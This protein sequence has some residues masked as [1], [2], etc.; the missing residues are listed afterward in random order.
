MEYC[1]NVEWER[2][3]GRYKLVNTSWL[4]GSEGTLAFGS[5][6]FLQFSLYRDRM[7]QQRT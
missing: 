1:E 7:P 5:G 6:I 3:Y 4:V 2:E